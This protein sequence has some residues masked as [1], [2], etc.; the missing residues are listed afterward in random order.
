MLG[1]Q[2][3]AARLGLLTPLHRGLNLAVRSFQRH[4]FLVRSLAAWAGGAGMLA[5][6][7]RPE[8]ALAARGAC[9]RRGLPHHPACARG[10]A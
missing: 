10:G 7:G 9:R 1:G 6:A 4:P 5:G 2:V 3:Q 8:V